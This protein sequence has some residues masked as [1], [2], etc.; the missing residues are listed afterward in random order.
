MGIDI[1]G[2][3][4]APNAVTSRP[5]DTR[6]FGALDSWF[7]DCTSALANDGTKLHAGIMNALLGQLRNLIR[8]NGLTAGSAQIVADDNSDDNMA[9][10]AIQHLI[11]RGQPSY[12][13]LAGSATAL[14]LALTPAAAEYK[15]G[16]VVIGK[17]QYDSTGPTT[18]NVNGL[19]AKTVI[20]YDGAP[21]G[22]L[23]MLAG[24]IMAFVYDGTNFQM[25]WAQ[26]QPGAPIFLTAGRT[27]YVNGILGSD[28]NDGK[29]AGVGA[30]A[31]LQKAIDVIS[32]FNLNGFNVV[33]NVADATYTIGPTLKMVGGSG[34]VFFVGNVATPPNVLIST[35][36][37]SAIIGTF[38]GAAYSFS[39][40]KVQ[41]TGA[42]AGDSISGVNIL[43]PGTAVELLNMNY[44]TCVGAHISSQ[45]SANVS[46]GG[47]Q[48]IS[49]GCAGNGLVPGWHIFTYQ[50][51]S[52]TASAS[53]PPSL[54]VSAAVTMASGFITAQYLG[55]TAVTYTAISNPSNLTGTKYFVSGNGVVNA[56]AT[57]INYYPGTSAGNT[58]TGG[59]Y[60]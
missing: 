8:G 13:A 44:G 53:S 31:T 29:A 3:A 10:K 41:A 16:M 56:F 11:Q 7:K 59:Q 27:Y 2:P 32:Q 35:N 20:R 24:G 30:F 51:G 17:V 47:T 19:G 23:D 28:A 14:T 46:V 33:V 48:T 57:G 45:T 22:A 1:V 42:A 12:A 36:N 34:K 55:Q 39:G 9:L 38:C 54:N 49:G 5:A 40:F 21:V 37:R 50:G 18:L 60:I 6:S 52:V 58:V 15:D 43:G 26:R 25:A 4:N